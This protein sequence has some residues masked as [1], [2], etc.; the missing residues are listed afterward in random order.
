MSDDESALDLSI[1]STD[2]S[3][4]QG[5]GSGDNA[6][7]TVHLSTPPAPM[8]MAP[9]SALERAD[10]AVRAAVAAVDAAQR[11]QEAA[12]GPARA[13]RGEE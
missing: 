10:A 13:M 8:G 11:E 4:D 2:R 12:Y 1:G 6:S 3:T 5:S 9:P 7:L